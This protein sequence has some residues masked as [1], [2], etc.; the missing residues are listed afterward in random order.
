MK[1]IR[2]II[3]AAA[4]V[5]AA[6]MI[7]SCSSCSKEKETADDNVTQFEKNLN[8][9]D[10]L[11]VKALVDEFFQYAIN[12]EFDAAA[13]MLYRSDRE[14][15]PQPLGEADTE[16]VM[17]MFRSFPMT[18][19]RI[20]YIKFSEDMNNEVMCYI[21]MQKAQEGMPEISTKMFLKPVKSDDEWFLCLT[22]TEY[23]DRGVVK[24][25]KRDSVK[26]SYRKKEREKTEK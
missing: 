14:E 26:R 15:K 12:Q 11:A 7:S 18:D 19:Y 8:E 1:H 6:L 13:A 5:A 24:P 20:E 10:T 21:I 4:C 17:V 22:N 9:V 23:G 16:Q 3:L 2:T 25:N